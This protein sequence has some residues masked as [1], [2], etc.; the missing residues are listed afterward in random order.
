MKQRLQKASKKLNKVA[1]ALEFSRFRIANPGV[2]VVLVSV[3][4]GG[5]THHAARR[6]TIDTRLLEESRALTTGVVEALQS[7]P[8][9]NRDNYTVTALELAKQDQRVVG[10]PLQPFDVQALIAGVNLTNGVPVPAEVQAAREEVRERFAQEDALLV[11]QAHEES[12]LLDLGAKAEA[13]RNEHITRWTKFSVGTIT[14]LGGAVALIIFC[15]LALPIAG[16]ILAWIVG[17]LPG[18]ASTF[19]VVS[20]H[21][22]DAVVRAVE[23]T[24]AQPQT[25]PA[26][27]GA[28][29]DTT[30]AAANMS[31]ASEAA[32]AENKTIPIYPVAPTVPVANTHIAPLPGDSRRDRV[33]A[34][35]FIDRLHNQLSREMDAAH[36]ALVRARKVRIT[37]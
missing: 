7:Q 6:Q 35:N 11:A 22:F 26:A 28:P 16:R 24:K 34:D 29:G 1:T 19:G 36:K 4:A 32:L 15:P 2:V 8:F 25:S 3:L 17:K 12:K 21:A 5:C 14:F 10:L 33:P 20:V 30:S 9:T 18:L 27:S 13:V 37:S 23:K 31:N